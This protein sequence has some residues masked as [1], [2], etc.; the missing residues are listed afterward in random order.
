M[1]TSV[2]TM[3]MSLVT[4]V[5]KKEM[6]EKKNKIDHPINTIPKTNMDGKWRIG[7]KK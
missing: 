6:R 2:R 1:E 3:L 5:K 4:A 7:Q